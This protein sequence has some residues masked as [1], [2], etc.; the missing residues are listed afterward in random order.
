MIILI[1]AGVDYALLNE[2]YPDLM[3]K[4]DLLILTPDDVS[5][6]PPRLWSELE[7]K[8][9]LWNSLEPAPY[10]DVISL[11]NVDR[12]SVISDGTQ[13]RPDSD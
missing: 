8:T 9:I 10:Q 5:Y 1:P 2:K 13:N 3:Q 4:P 6:I 12:F 11:N 7:P